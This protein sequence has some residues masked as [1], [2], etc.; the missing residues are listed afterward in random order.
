[1]G[2]PR[3]AI[4]TIWLG[5]SKVPLFYLIS[6]PRFFFTKWQDMRFHFVDFSLGKPK[7]LSGINAKK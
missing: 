2:P 1:M 7:N 4:K 5:S 6:Q 3:R